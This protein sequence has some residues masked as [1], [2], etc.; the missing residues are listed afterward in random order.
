MAH[1]TIG[2]ARKP[3]AAQAGRAR[4]VVVALLTWLAILGVDFVLNGA[5]F[6]RM[7]QGGDAFLLAPQQAFARIPLGYA[8]FLIVAFAVV[9]LER[10]VGIS[11]PRAGI[12]FGLVLGAVSGSVWALG[13]Y[14]IASVPAAVAL[15][16]A[17]IWFAVLLVAS[18]VAAAALGQRSL[19]RVAL[20]VAGFDVV[21]I[22][23]VVALQSFGV[24]PAITG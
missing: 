3:V 7:Y 11:G 19:R 15:A 13:L 16:L 22:V 14:S 20:A 1:A 4:R 9:E 6:A 23:V 17:A 2:A 21:C 8:A 5:I 24:V 12:R 10:L 18:T